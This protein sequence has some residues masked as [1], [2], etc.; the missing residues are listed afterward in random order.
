MLKAEKSKEKLSI[1]LCNIDAYTSS[2]KIGEIINQYADDTE[3]KEIKKELTSALNKLSLHSD[4]VTAALRL[5]ESHHQE[6]LK[7][8]EVE[9]GTSFPQ[10]W[11]SG[12]KCFKCGKDIIEE[13]KT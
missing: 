5:A 1:L 4:M 9:K 12:V 2:R 7:S 8:D 10:K 3:V 6:E 13:S 11:T